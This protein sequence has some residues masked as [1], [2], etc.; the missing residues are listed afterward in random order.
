MTFARFQFILQHLFWWECDAIR[1]VFVSWSN[2]A[3][4]SGTVS[5]AQQCVSSSNQKEKPSGSLF[6]SANRS[7]SHSLNTS[8]SNNTCFF[9]LMDRYKRDRQHK[10]H[11]DK[12]NVEHKRSN[13]QRSPRRHTSPTRFE[14]VL[15]CIS[16]WCPSYFISRCCAARC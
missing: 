4:I 13:N 10:R 16:Y 9:F 7:F 2:M 12:R 15:R 14:H 3:D 11:Y 5:F 1:N 6:C 8:P